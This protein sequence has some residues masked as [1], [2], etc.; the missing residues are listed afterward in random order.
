[1]TA[2]G[3]DSDLTVLATAGGLTLTDGTAGG[4]ITL[5]KQGADGILSA[6]SLSAGTGVKLRSATDILVDDVQTASGDLDFGADGDV[7]A[8]AREWNRRSDR[9]RRHDRHRQ[10][11]RARRHRARRRR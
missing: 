8:A 7:T 5:T 6:G 2:N 10:H 9:R 1:M 3:T 4:T 11:Q